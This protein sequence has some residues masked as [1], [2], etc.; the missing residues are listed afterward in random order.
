MSLSAVAPQQSRSLRQS[1]FTMVELMV[2]VAIMAVLLTI[3]APSF[4]EIMLSTRLASFANSFI[5]SAQLA[6]SEAIKRNAQVR[7]CR[8]TTSTSCASSGGWQQGWVVFLD[9][10]GN[11]AVDFNTD[12]NLDDTIIQKQAALVTGFQLTGNSYSVAFQS[13][14]DIPNSVSLVLCRASPLGAQ[15]RRI[16]ISTLGKAGVATERTGVCT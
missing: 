13:M 16:T 2:T 1:G 9:R 10:N 15:E 7:V 3:A 8:S 14:G 6:R 11:G 4:S 5:A 12:P